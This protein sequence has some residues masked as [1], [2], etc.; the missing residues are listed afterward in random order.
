M[1]VMVRDGENWRSLQY[2]ER[3]QILNNGAPSARDATIS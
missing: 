2:Y 1:P 3:V